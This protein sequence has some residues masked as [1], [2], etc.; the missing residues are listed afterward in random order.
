MVFEMCRGETPGVYLLE[1]ELDLTAVV[2]LDDLAGHVEEPLVLDLE[3]L[4]FMD[5]SGLRAVL[6]LALERDD[7]HPVVLRR[8]NRPTMRLLR[9]T[10][11]NGAPGLRVED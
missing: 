3:R 5:S 6:R 4:S 10:M 2:H 9:M 7:D 8:P 11:P 1:G